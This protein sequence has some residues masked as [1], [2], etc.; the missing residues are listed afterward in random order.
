M[1]LNRIPHIYHDTI[2]AKKLFEIIE[3]KHIRLASIFKELGNF[4]N[5][6]ASR[7]ILLD[8]LGNNFKVPRLGRSDDE[9]RKIIGFEISSLQFIGNIE[10]IKRVLATYFDESIDIFLINE[11]SGKIVL[12][13]PNTVDE[14]E[15]LKLV[16][17]IK[18]AGVGL[19]VVFEIY[20][21]DFLVS[22]IDSKRVEEVGK[23]K[24]SRR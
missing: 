15:V 17:R 13:I 2:Y 1:K 11:L 9:Y 21:E 24:I 20:V 8:V 16:K 3:K 12:K 6:K 10:E 23:I 22:E 18:T 5:L 14:D 7:G 4:N 19:N